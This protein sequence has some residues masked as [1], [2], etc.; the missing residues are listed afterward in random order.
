MCTSITLK[1]NCF[2]FGRNLDL[3]YDFNQEVL[4]TPRNLKIPLKNGEILSN[5]FAMI[6][7]GTNANGIALY[8]DAV[9]EKGLAMAGLNFPSF[10][11]YQEPCVGKLN[12]TPYEIIPLILGKCASVKQAKELLNDMNITNIPY[13]ANYPLTPLHWMLADKHECIVI[14]QEKDGLHVYENPFGV[15]T[16]N[17]PFYFH[18]LNM[19]QYMN[20]DAHNAINTFADKLPLKTFGQG[21]GG[22]GLPGDYSPASRFVLASFLKN[23]SIC[24]ND[25]ESSI[26]QGFHILDGVA[27]VKGSVITPSGLP[28]ITTYASLMNCDEG[29]YYYKTY[30]NNQIN[31]VRLFN[32]PLNSEELI[33]FK[34]FDKQQ[35]YF[36]N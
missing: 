23:N 14:E 20:V 17:P 29:I 27:M 24:D 22:I 33:S 15:L 13:S 18:Q 31:A 25:E 26:A 9:N 6:G 8:A 30:N 5:H 2:Y 10:A 28:D 11:H 7:M 35:I 12:I 32:A 21:M 34:L 1:T 19:N 36:H 3:E 16:N 4:I